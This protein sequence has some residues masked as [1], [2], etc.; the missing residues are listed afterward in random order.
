MGLEF[1]SN[2]KLKMRSEVTPSMRTE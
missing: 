2:Y 1:D